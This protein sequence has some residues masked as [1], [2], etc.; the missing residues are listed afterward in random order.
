M[1]ENMWEFGRKCCISITNISSER[2]ES[3]WWHSWLINFTVFSRGMVH[4]VCFNTL[5]YTCLFYTFLFCCLVSDEDKSLSSPFT[6]APTAS[7]IME[8]EKQTQQ[9]TLPGGSSKILNKAIEKAEHEA[10]KVK[11]FKSKPQ[12]SKQLIEFQIATDFSIKTCSK[13]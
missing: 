1:L 3:L 7:L 5:C 13:F 2:S 8:K 11:Q 10:K 9:K 6:Q 12:F 4:N